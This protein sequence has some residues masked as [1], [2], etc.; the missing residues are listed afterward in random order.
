[1]NDVPVISII[2][3]VYNVALYLRE[4]LDSVL[5]QT[6]TDWEAICV[7]DGSTD[8]SGAILDEYAAKDKRFRIIHQKNSGVSAARNAALDVACGEW[9]GFMDADDSWEKNWLK[10][11]S[12]AVDENLD[13]IRTG[14]TDYDSVESVQKFT[15]QELTER[16]FFDEK[17]LEIGWRAISRCSCPFVNLYR[18]NALRNVR[19]PKGIRFREDAL[20]SYEAA[21]VCS[22]LAIIP[23]VGYLRRVHDGSATYSPRRR[24]DTINL[25]EG[26]LHLW[27]KVFVEGGRY[28]TIGIVEASTHWVRK[29]VR[30]WF[31]LCMD[32]TIGDGWKVWKL[33]RKLLYVGAISQVGVGGRFDKLRWKMYLATGIGRILFINKFNLFGM[34]RKDRVSHGKCNNIRNI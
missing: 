30:E 21:A 29:D 23:C 32:R 20:F 28:A 2:I 19:F 16:K 10:E 14:W 15:L 11:V 31:A 33:L 7:D 12:S 13:W 34:R 4:C 8:G 17:A 9:V 5:A 6:F 27:R 26:Y 3:P 22:G 18:R 25:L 24:N 1:M